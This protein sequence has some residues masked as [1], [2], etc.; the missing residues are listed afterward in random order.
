MK[1][2]KILV[3][4]LVVFASGYIYSAYKTSDVPTEEQ[5]Q[6]LAATAWK[7]PV[8]SID[9]TFYKDYT[10]V[11][12]PIEQ[13]RK[14]AEEFVDREFKGRSIDE[15]KPYEIERRNRI[16]EENFKTWVENQK[17]PRK[18]KCRVWIS[19]NNQRIDMVT[20][21]PNEPLG[22]NTPFVHTFINTK[23]AN[24]GDFVSYH[25]AG[26]MNAVFVD[27]KK[28]A[29]ETVTQ[30][31]DMPVLTAIGLQFF[32]GTDQGSTPKSINYISDPNKMAELARTGL[33]TIEPI[34]GA[35]A[36]GNK[37]VN[38]IGI[39]SDPDSPGARDIIKMGDPNH[40]PTV[41]LICDREDYS[42]IYRFEGRNPTTNQIM[43]VR[44]CNDFDSQGFPHN[45]TEIQYDKDGNL[46]EKSV[47]RIIKVE[48]NPSI[49][50]DVFE[51][52]PP[53]GY[54]IVDQ[55]SKKP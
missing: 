35:K 33:A 5:V 29:K 14:R 40:F 9:V 22:P 16:I 37:A 10:K 13:I 30:F 25:Y 52:H 48:L 3:L 54:K 43:Y 1:W 28:W 21:G 50:A 8:K 34:R 15:L 12:E 27:T 32:L 45:V 11:P 38:R 55:R 44:E 6:K 18:A 17:Y 24:T 51:F 47:Y 20:V 42:R 39:R 41:V 26:E 19:G 53:E 7:E 23:D 31:A 49:P 46:K 36:K 4:L 2:S